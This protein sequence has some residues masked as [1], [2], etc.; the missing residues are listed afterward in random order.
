MAELKKQHPAQKEKII[1]N[2]QNSLLDELDEEESGQLQIL[3][4]QQV[5]IRTQQRNGKKCITLIQN[6]P[7]EYDLKK[8]AKALRK[9]YACNGAVVEHKIYG[10]VVIL[11]GDK[12]MSIYEFLTKVGLVKADNI[13][14]H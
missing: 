5:H 2:N 3:Q 4:D 8:L 7:E 11:Q 12:R 6:M 9:T 1:F 10:E 13:K 14:F